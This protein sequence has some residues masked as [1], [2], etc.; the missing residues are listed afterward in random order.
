MC[1]GG[2]P[3][4]MFIKML[5]TFSSKQKVVEQRENIPYIFLL[6]C[7]CVIGNNQNVLL[8]SSLYP[9]FYDITLLSFLYRN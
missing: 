1:P 2:K 8:I 3:V 7:F 9:I 6:L 4:G 5:G